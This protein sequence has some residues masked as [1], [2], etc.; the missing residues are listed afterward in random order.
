MSSD[1]SEQIDSHAEE[2]KSLRSRPLFVMYYYETAGRI[3]HEDVRDVYDEFRRRGWT[4]N[5]LHDDLDVL[6]HC[7]GGDANASYRVGQILH[8]FAK[9]IAFLVP[10]H[11][12][13]GGTIVCLG[14]YEIRLGAY[15]SLSPIDIRLGNIE[16]ASIDSYKKFAIDCRRDVERVLDENNSERT[17][18]VESALLCELVEQNTGLGIG[19]LYR[20]KD[21]TG[22]YAFRLMYDYMFSEHSNRGAMAQT[23]T[24]SLLREFPSHSYVLD[25]HMSALIKL[26]V[27][28]MNEEESEKTKAFVNFLDELV[29]Q[30]IICRDIGI[31]E[32]GETLKSP[33]FRL[34][35]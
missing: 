28:E 1:I 5:E 17:T 34:Y 32:E 15:S 31:S 14:G 6:I 12:T 26:P 4:R 16:L 11:A 13:S 23:I 19:T 21:L 25:Y 2:I 30:G 29:R 20:L 7:Y 10:F 9:K 35:T 3:S 27:M 24:D 8:D 18:N 33:F 22:H